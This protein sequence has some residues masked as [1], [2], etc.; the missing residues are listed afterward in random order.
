[1]GNTPR[2]APHGPGGGRVVTMPQTWYARDYFP[3]HLQ[4]LALLMRCVPN[5]DPQFG[6]RANMEA[7]FHE[8]KDRG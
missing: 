5:S 4:V 3:L 2:T 6:T 8:I 7:C 1:M